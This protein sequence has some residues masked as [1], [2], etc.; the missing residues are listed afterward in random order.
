MHRWLIISWFVCSCASPGRLLRPLEGH[1]TA[2]DCIARVRVFDGLADALTAP[3]DVRL[4]N[5]RIESIQPAAQRLPTQCLDGT[6]KT[7]LPGLIDSHTHV[8]LTSG[9][10]PWDARLPDRYR[11]LEMFL[12]AGVTTVLVAAGSDMMAAL[13]DEVR[14][15]E[16]LG[17]TMF[18]ASRMITAKQ[19]H[20]VALYEAS[21]PWPLTSILI[22]RDLAQVSTPDEVPAV[23]EAQRAMRP[24]FLKVVYDDLPA[25]G[26]H[27]DPQT[28]KK[29]IAEGARLGVRVVVHVGSPREAVEAAEAGASLLM[30]IPWEE[31]LSDEDVARIAATK[32]PMVT[33]R[34]IYSALDDALH[35]RLVMHPTEAAVAP[36]GAAESFAHRPKNFAP[37]GFDSNFEAVLPTYDR[38][39]GE[40]LKKLE[41]AGVALLIGT[42][43]GLPGV[44][45]G[46]SIHRE[47]QAIVA[48][49]IPAATALRAATSVPARFLDPSRRFGVVEPGAI[50]DLLL[51]EGDPLEDIKATEAT[52]AVWKGGRRLHPTSASAR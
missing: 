24:D 16:V 7:L 22:G 14:R 26:P 15:G 29:I 41:A 19:G 2:P 44:F 42:D 17:P 36:A 25:G 21:V 12:H 35:E 20:P 51:V 47:L 8:G 11:H 9:L 46:A 31:V 39:L 43:A 37:A 34:R 10:P 33:T 13:S 48:L 23:V 52:V 1:Q 5:G 18:R 50:A 32:V 45:Q 49:G 40:N 6:G 4:A 3:M 38:N 30:H 28:L 27:L